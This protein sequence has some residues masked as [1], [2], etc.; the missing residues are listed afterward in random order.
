MEKSWCSREVFLSDVGGD[1]KINYFL[2]LR[3]V[4][5]VAKIK[6]KAIILPNIVEAAH[7]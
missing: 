6:R 3:K 4:E 7:H 5:E 2:K 1:K